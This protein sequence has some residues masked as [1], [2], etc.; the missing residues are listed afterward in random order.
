V[1]WQALKAEA[2]L[3]SMWIEKSKR[4]E[5]RGD[6]CK[7]L[8]PHENAI[9]LLPKLRRQE[10][11]ID[12]LVEERDDPT[13]RAWKLALR[14]DVAYAFVAA[15]RAENDLS[16]VLANSEVWGGGFNSPDCGPEVVYQ[17]A[18]IVEACARCEIARTIS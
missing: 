12:R 18:A 17:L 1:E 10:T 5:P 14:T 3:E 13:F 2:A 11:L 9:R 6:R 8:L 16:S 7:N 15:L 4:E